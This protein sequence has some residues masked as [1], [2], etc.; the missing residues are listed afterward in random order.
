MATTIQLTKEER[1]E[2]FREIIHKS[3]RTMNLAILAYFAFGLMLAPF[4]DTWGM[5]LTGG[6][7]CVAAF[8]ATRYLLPEFRLYQ[9]VMSAVLALFSAQFIYQM[10]G[11]F[12]MHF[13]FFVGSALLI[14]YR[15]WRLMI[16]LAAI[17]IIHHAAFAWLQYQG[18]KEIYFTQLDYMNL[19]AFTFH[20][21][22]AT[23]IMGICAYWAYDLERST[24]RDASNT[25]QLT[26]QLATVKNNI[27]FA[28]DISAGNFQSD[29]TLLDEA[30][31][32]GKAL[33]LMRDNLRIS[34]AREREEKFITTGI[35]Q[36]SDIIRFHGNDSTKLAD[37]FMK[38]LIKYVG[39]NQGALFIQEEDENGDFLQM[40]ACY[41]YER[42][43]F[44]VKRVEI[45]Q[46]L[47][48]QCFQEREPIY[49]TAVPAN[50]VQITSGLGEATPR[51]ILLQPVKDQDEIVG[52][53]EVASFK[54]LDAHEREFIRRSADIIASA[55]VG[56]RTTARIQR[57]LEESQSKAENMRAQ[58]EEL[59]QN[60][61]ELS[62][63]QEEM[64]R[65]SL[66]MENRI[67]AVEEAGMAYIE[68]NLD[69]TIID[70]NAN[71]L[72]LMKYRRDEIVGKH[73]RIFVDSAYATS[74]AYETFWSNLR[75][76]NLQAGK[77]TRYAKDGSEVCIQG[78]YSVYYDKHGRPAKIAKVAQDITSLVKREGVLSMAQD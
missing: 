9:Y 54:T 11:L 77:F 75:K 69:G 45:G 63:T 53:L 12:E 38:C 72:N 43:K 29:Y 50:Y 1:K 18:L 48:G 73:H 4:Y 23:V 61:E 68:F 32:L 36:V 64:Q 22:L 17:T 70:A 39:L 6:G 71:L 13:F 26:R 56:N 46:G 65:K 34:S 3:D 19:Q 60:M 47:V 55:V 49:I 30:D 25:S 20:A 78:S 24:L 33:L 74:E 31:E 59:R 66:E 51:C 7:I 5:A 40:A 28:N 21:T 15:N 42:K 44:M 2:A 10:H 62:A 16:P 37:E 52:V 8:F 58:E 57:L 27:Q 35:T 41:A 14:T 67:R 76:G